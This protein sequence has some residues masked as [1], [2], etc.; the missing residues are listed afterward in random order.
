MPPMSSS[1]RP[2]SS[3][4][5]GRAAGSLASALMMS[6]SS[7][8]GTSLRIEVSDAGVVV[9]FLWRISMKLEPSYGGL[10]DS[11]S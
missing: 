8:A 2:S 7:A 10:P 4:D 5:C 11:I 3:I 9:A 1:A 6:A